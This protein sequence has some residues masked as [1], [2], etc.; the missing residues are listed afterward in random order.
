[1]S[2]VP[3]HLL[4]TVLDQLLDTV[5]LV[6]LQGTIVYASAACRQ[7]LGYTPEEL[8]GR[9]MLDLVAPE[10]HEATLAEARKVIAGEARIGFENRYVRKDGSRVP[11]MW[12]ARLDETARLRIGVARDISERKRLEARQAATYAISEAVH[13]ATDLAQLFEQVHDIVAGLVSVAGLAVVL[14]A[15]VGVPLSIGYCEVSPTAGVAMSADVIRQ[16]GAEAMRRG[17]VVVF[18]GAEGAIEAHEAAMAVA[19]PLVAGPDVVGA[20]LLCSQPGAIYSAADQDLLSFVSLQV[21]IAVRRKQM[22]TALEQAARFDE[23]TGL[24]NRRHFQE[25]LPIVLARCQ[26]HRRRF[27]LMFLDIDDFKHV[28]DRHGHVVGDHLLQGVAR[29]LKVCLREDDAVFR[30]GGDEFVVLLEDVRDEADASFVAE[31]LLAVVAEPLWLEGVALRCRMSVGLALFPD[32]GD[33]LETLL[34][35]ADQAMYARKRQE[36]RASARSA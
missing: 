7:S 27:A 10:D 9:R 6:D 24:P 26:R 28:N 19:V 25:R 33:S 31:R 21:A 32:H 14:R 36:A 30:L 34:T 11:F 20:L 35:H 17:G 13:E 22:V 23:L 15:P 8:V 5:F 29:R 18:A 12:S 2:N 1:M 4:S 16:R 3:E